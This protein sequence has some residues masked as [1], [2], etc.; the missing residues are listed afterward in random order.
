MSLKDAFKPGK[1]K[2]LGI[3]IIFAL[4]ATYGFVPPLTNP[5]TCVGGCLV[6]I[7][8]P[9][10]FFFYNWNA[11]TESFM[12]FNY[13]IFTIDIVIFY[14]ALSLISLIFKIGRRKN[15]PDSNSGGRDSSPAD[16]AGAGYQEVR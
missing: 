13:I 10:Q 4:M 7:G 14:L 6:E 12:D 15:V 2:V 8:W 3:I 9:F 5:Q 16:Q 1:G 11:T